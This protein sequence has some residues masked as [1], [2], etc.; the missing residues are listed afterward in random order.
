MW[1]SSE[2]SNS[3][4][5][6]WDADYPNNMCEPP[7]QGYK[8]EMVYTD[9]NCVVVREQLQEC[10]YLSNLVTK[11][12]EEYIWLEVQS[13]WIIWTL[14]EGDGFHDRHQDLAN[15]G[16]TVYTIVI[17]LGSLELQA[18]AGEINNINIDDYAYA[19][20]VEAT[21]FCNNFDRDGEGV[22]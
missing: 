3:V 4:L 10:G 8:L 22:F 20:D 5:I 12:E 18:V 13:V 2:L 16:Q 21:S 11:F 14:K 9:Q 19:H 1:V 7:P 6:N 17:N 15:N